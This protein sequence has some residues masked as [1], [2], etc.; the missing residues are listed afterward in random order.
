METQEQPLRALRLPQV[1]DKTGISRS[2]IRRMVQ[3]GK[4]PAP[5]HLTENGSISA[6][7][8][9]EIDQ[10]LLEKFQEAS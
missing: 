8:E 5:Y 10:W 9:A 2:Q 7:S 3:A 1:I 4:F 6:W